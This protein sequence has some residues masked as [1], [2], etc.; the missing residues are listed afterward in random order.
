MGHSES[1]PPDDAVGIRLDRDFPG[2]QRRGAEIGLTL[3]HG[4]VAL[5]ERR[6]IVSRLTDR[7]G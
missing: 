2:G 3:H 4:F 6:R 1:E 7:G 5:Q